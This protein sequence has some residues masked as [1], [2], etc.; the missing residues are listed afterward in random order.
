[1]ITTLLF[2]L[3]GTLLE[4]EGGIL[5]S[6]RRTL[7]T[8]NLPDRS[9]DELKQY[10]GPPLKH[11]WAE[12]VG[13]DL[14]EVATETYRQTYDQSGK[15]NA[16]I[17]EGLLPALGTLSSSYQ[18]T[19]ATSKRRIFALDMLKHFGLT[20]YF[21][22]IYGVNPD[23]L[24]EPK[25]SLI[26]RLLH[27]LEVSPSQAVMIGDRKFDLIGANENNLRSIGVLWGYGSREELEAHNPSALCP[28]TD[29]LVDTINGLA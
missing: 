5:D 3:D 27:D 28:T 18:L 20:Q 29:Q 17:Y 25:A 2:D 14:V 6:F 11:A 15:F 1:M 19:V 16:K 24:S 23:N 12:L 21:K 9:D 7:Q 4:T 26:A 8:L 10:I 13:E 22:A